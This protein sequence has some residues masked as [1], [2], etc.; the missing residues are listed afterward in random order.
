MAIYVSGLGY[1]HWLATLAERPLREQLSTPAFQLLTWVSLS[2][3]SLGFAGSSEL[4]W[5]QVAWII[6]T[7][8]AFFNLFF[9]WRSWQNTHT[10]THPAADE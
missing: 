5:E 1:Q 2:L 6:L 3:I 7:G 9:K 10:H 4:W 8:I